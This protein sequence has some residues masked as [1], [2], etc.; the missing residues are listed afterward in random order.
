[1]NDDKTIHFTEEGLQLA[2]LTLSKHN[3]LKR[4]LMN[5]GIDAETAEREAC[6]ME[7]G[8]S[9]ESFLKLKAAYPQE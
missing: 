1:M 8:I 4:F 5:A 7:H 6:A 9:E 3:Y 2:E